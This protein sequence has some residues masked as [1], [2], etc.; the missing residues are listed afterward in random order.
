MLPP[1][2]SDNP[3]GEYPNSYL[4][5]LFV[6]EPIDSTQHLVAIFRPFNYETGMIDPTNEHDSMFTVDDI[7]VEAARAPKLGQVMYLITET[8][9]LLF[10]EKSLEKRIAKLPDGAEKTAAEQRLAE[11]KTALGVA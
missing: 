5:Q 1:I 8:A 7:R 11:V 4:T 10:E 9:S 6:T 3:T 2:Y